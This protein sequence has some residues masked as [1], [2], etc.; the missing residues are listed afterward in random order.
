MT[1]PLQPAERRL[2]ALLWAHAALSVA[3]AAGYVV[4]GDTQ[5]LG[6]IPNSVAKDGLFAILS[7]LGA[8]DV[9]RRGWAAPV[10][11]GAYAALILGEA[12]TLLHG[13]APAQDVLGVHVSGTVALLAW[14]AVDIVLAGWLLAWWLAAERARIGLRYL[15]PVAF[16]GLSTLADV[17]IEGADEKVPP[18]DIARNVDAYFAELRAAG[19]A[20]VH[21]ALTVLGLLPPWLPLP[22]RGPDGRKRFLQRNFI[23]DV[24]E[25]RLPAPVRPLVQALVRT[26]SQMTYLGYYGDKRSWPSIGY[27]PFVEREGGREP[28]EA[29]HPFGRLQTLATP[30][31]TRYD[32]VIVGS[33]AAGSI[34]A[35]RFAERGKRVLLLERGPHA[36]P[37]EFTG[38]E[39]SQYLKLY[40]EGALQLATDFRLQV[41][42][43]M[44][45][46]G[47]TTVNNGVCLDPPGPVLDDWAQRG[48]DRAGLERAVREVREWLRVQPIAA[49]TVSAGA[50]RFADGVAALG[51]PG[52]IKRVD[53]NL[54]DSCLGCGY[55]NIGCAYGKRQSMLDRILPA[56]QR[57]SG[58]V[59]VL[60]D[61]RALELTR[62]GDRVTGV[63]GEHAGR[64]RCSVRGDEVIVAAGAL[65]SS[66]LLQRSGIGGDRAGA[67]LHF[68]IN[69]PLTADFPEPVDT[70]A[71]LQMTHAY[72]P[73]GD[74]PAYVLETWFNPPA[75]Q[76]LAMPGWFGRH[77]RN[78]LRYRH[79]VAGG[80]LVGT[81]RPGRVTATRQGPQVRYTPSHADLGRVVEGI[82]LIGNIYLA[83]GAER[84]M[85]ATFAW[86]EYSSR[87]A[88]DDLDTL[89]RDNTDLL[90][91]T[92][93][94]QG[95]NAI[96][97]PG[98]GGVV[99]PD[100]RVHGF[101]NLYLCDASA[102]PSSVGVNPQ[103]TVMALA[104]HAA[105]TILG[106]APG[107]PRQWTAPEHLTGPPEPTPAG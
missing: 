76:S 50:Q 7:V 75:T 44:C 79:M 36:D 97:E 94:P 80:A 52:T 51:L 65:G 15:N 18:A 72:E 32:T 67:A 78:M 64:N 29:D 53:A 95:G 37:R 31:R 91:T 39:V 73:P 8:A 12:I 2:R 1:T 38:D 28:V 102:F 77:Y 86:R 34:L 84:V 22:L 13:G 43:G 92:A 11:A 100:F 10:L 30:P 96:G 45:V 87:S 101:A 35:Y 105:H 63:L 70:F 48:I 62:E 5:T 103:L 27:V 83:A 58:E 49:H 55:C 21:L 14:M 40:N 106:P 68:N 4:G 26:A 107:A 98:Q 74:E 57:L 82:K 66:W 19:K 3:F 71:G 25:R 93:H 69:S 23:D 85:P 99:G 46:G 61:F 90:L 24:A 81:T 60:P 42:Q 59:D 41:L 56:A 6:F 9:R 89:V 47:G 16:H 20:R 104:Q 88:L 33:G 17:L 54:L